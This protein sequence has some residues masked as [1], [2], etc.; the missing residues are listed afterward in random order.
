MAAL[1]VGKP[2]PASAEQAFGFSIDRADRA[3]W[4]KVAGAHPQWPP[5]APG[6][7]YGVESEFRICTSSFRNAA[8]DLVRGSGHV[9]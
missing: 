9:H 5:P 1:G 7:S 6:S 2:H 4:K 3:E 8:V